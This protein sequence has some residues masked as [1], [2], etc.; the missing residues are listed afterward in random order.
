MHII[1]YPLLIPLKLREGEDLV[2]LFQQFLLPSHVRQ[3]HDESHLHH[4]GAELPQRDGAPGDG[5]HEERLDGA[6]AFLLG[7]EELVVLIDDAVLVHIRAGVQDQER[8]EAPAPESD[9]TDV[10]P[11]TVDE[12]H[13]R[14]G[15]DAWMSGEDVL[16]AHESEYTGSGRKE[17]TP[18]H[19]ATICRVL[20]AFPGSQVVAFEKNP[21][22]EKE[23]RS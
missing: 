2:S 8:I 6:G 12:E 19:A 14:T 20:E 18:E 22:P 16:A 10:Q 23:A 15:S 1:P 5:L 13:P 17:I 7:D 9:G 3:V 21:K 11:I 4:D